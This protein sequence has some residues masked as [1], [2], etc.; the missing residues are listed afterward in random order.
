[1]NCKLNSITRIFVPLI[2]A[3]AQHRT[4]AP[5]ERHFAIPKISNKVMSS[6]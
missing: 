5:T 1:M 3:T 2:H 4:D 6:H